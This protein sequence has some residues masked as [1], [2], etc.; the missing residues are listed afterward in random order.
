MHPPVV[1]LLETREVPNTMEAWV[2]TIGTIDCG[3]ETMR[4]AWPTLEHRF[5]IRREREEVDS[6]RG[7]RPWSY[8]VRTPSISRHTAYP[9]I[10][11]FIGG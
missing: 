6:Q 2:Q 11:G 9:V 4:A 8:S 7:A 5:A 10:H 1:G 3:L